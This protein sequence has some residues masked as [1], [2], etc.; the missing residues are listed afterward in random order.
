ML[1]VT[2]VALQNFQFWGLSKNTRS[3]ISKEPILDF[4]VSHG[5]GVAQKNI[6]SILLWAPSIAGEQHYLVI[7][8]GRS[9]DSIAPTCNVSRQTYKIG[10]ITKGDNPL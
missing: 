6:S 1:F 8:E 10:L 2:S 3:K 5:G 9:I 4:H 7:S